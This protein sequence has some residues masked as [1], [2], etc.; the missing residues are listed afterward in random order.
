MKSVRV[1]PVPPPARPVLVMMVLRLLDPFPLKVFQSVAVNIPVLVVFANTFEGAYVAAATADCKYVTVAELEVRY[2]DAALLCIRYVL[3]A[4]VVERY[5][6]AAVVEIKDV[7]KLLIWVWRLAVDTDRAVVETA[8]TL[9]CVRKAAVDVF[10]AAIETLA[11]VSETFNAFVETPSAVI[12]VWRLVVE[13]ASAV[14]NVPCVVTV[15]AIEA[16]DTPTA[17]NLAMRSA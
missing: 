15:E 16:V 5:P 17:V 1:G 4:V 9:S 14:N 7:P 11:A 6:S 8:T 10:K 2:V 3:A 13:R 12:W